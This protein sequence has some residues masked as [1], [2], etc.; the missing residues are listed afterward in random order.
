M[1]HIRIILSLLLLLFT[2]SGFAQKSVELSLSNPSPG[3]G[4]VFYINIR[5][6]N[7]S[8]RLSRPSDAPGTKLLYFT[9]K[10][11][12][13][14]YVVDNG[15]SSSNSEAVYSITLRADKEGKFSYGPISLGGV[16]SNTV[17]Y[18]IG[19]SP[20]PTAPPTSPRLVDRGGSDLF[21]KAIVSNTSPYEHEPVVY[22]IRLYSSYDGTEVKGSPGAPQFENCTY[23]RTKYASTQFRHEKVNG[24]DYL[25]ADLLRY[26]VFPSKAGEMQ[27]KGNTFTFSVK[28]MLQYEGEYGI[29]PVFPGS[30]IEATVP[31]VKLSVR[32][33]PQHQGDLNGVGDYRVS[34]QMSR[35]SLSVNQIA[36]VKYTVAG[37]GNLAF[38][39]MPDIASQ[40]PEELKFV[41][42]EDNVNS[43]VGDTSVS[44]SV[45][46]TVSLIPTKEGAYTIP[47]LTFTFFDAEKGVY[48]TRKAPGFKVNVSNRGA[49]DDK[50]SQQAHKFDSQ[51]QTIRSLSASQHFSVMHFG[52]YLFFIVPVALL[53]LAVLVYRRRIKI[54]S[55]VIGR[56][57]RKASKI[58]RQRL[59]TA[60]SLMRKGS[61]AAFYTEL[62]RALW[63]YIAFKLNMS[64]S[65]LE[66][67][68]VRDRL[69]EAGASEDS[70]RR[71]IEVIDRCEEA[72]YAPGE[73]SDLKADYNAAS[74]LIDSLEKELGKK[75]HNLN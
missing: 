72:K 48:Y 54:Q 62:L 5:V 57:S 52:Y 17:S 70:V 2:L 33:L 42:T 45:E 50:G 11:V 51:L 15:H 71:A 29:M 21:L 38:M 20:S 13:N 63:G 26:I 41:K 8:E 65:E 43:K 35:V 27:I 19:K 16:K 66:R 58:A 32:S 69:L 49:V 18:T 46:Y 60:E 24:R 39:S 61:D 4:E 22:T 36:T 12:S 28:Q 59:R 44:G 37:S 23:E 6:R 73:N 31:T 25:V 75:I 64:T 74:S 9:L 14:S 53:L 40:L 47:E 34:S 7:I 10:G 3:V 55:D 67:L 30:T 68:N 56:R 1:K